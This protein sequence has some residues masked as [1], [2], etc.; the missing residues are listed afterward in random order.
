MKPITR[1]ELKAW[2][3]SHEDFILV[4]TLPEEYYNDWHLPGAINVPLDDNFD[5][6]IQ[7]LIPDKGQGVVV[8]CMNLECDMSPKAGT[9]MVELGY[10]RVF[11]YQEGKADWKE[12]GLPVETG[13]QH[14][15]HA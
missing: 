13:T 3:D 8:Y 2:L 9:R 14:P 12:V 10:T 1:D 11:D 6:Q 4:E 5:D 7:Q 15:A